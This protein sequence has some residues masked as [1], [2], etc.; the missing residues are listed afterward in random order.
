MLRRLRG[1]KVYVIENGIPHKLSRT[2]G[3]TDH[4]TA[5]SAVGSG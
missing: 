1:I 5:L 2:T 4:R 3:K